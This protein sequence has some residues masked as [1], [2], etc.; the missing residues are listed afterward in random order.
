MSKKIFRLNLKLLTKNAID[1]NIAEYNKLI[2][3]LPV[4]NKFHKCVCLSV[5][6][7]FK[8]Q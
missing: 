2:L 5:T 8:P 1:Q 3:T 7:T 6:N 4:Y